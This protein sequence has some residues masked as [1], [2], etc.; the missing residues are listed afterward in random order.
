MAGGGARWAAAEAD[1]GARR[2]L[3][4]GGLAGGGADA[5]DARGVTRDG[6][7]SESEAARWMGLTATRGL[8][9]HNLYPYPQPRVYPPPPVSE[10]YGYQTY[11]G[12][13]NQE[14]SCGWSQQQPSAPSDGPY[15]YGYN[16]DPD[17]LTFLRGWYTYTCYT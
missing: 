9:V 11:F 6:D 13:D 7:G 14:A 5:V 8:S 3:D 15:N 1:G 12:E 4:G 16:D 2:G 10:G 17:C